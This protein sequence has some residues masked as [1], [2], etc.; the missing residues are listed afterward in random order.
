[1]NVAENSDAAQ[2]ASFVIINSHRA[3]VYHRE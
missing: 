1:M 3:N 2:P